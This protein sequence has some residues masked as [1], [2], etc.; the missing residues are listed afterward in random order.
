MIKNITFNLSVSVNHK[1]LLVLLHLNT[2]C[3]V[4]LSTDGFIIAHQNNNPLFE[5]MLCIIIYTKCPVNKHNSTGKEEEKRVKVK[6]WY[7][8]IVSIVNQNLI[9]SRIPD[10][11]KY[12]NSA[13][14]VI[15]STLLLQARSVGLDRSI[16]FIDMCDTIFSEQRVRWEVVHYCNQFVI[17]SWNGK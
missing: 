16:I 2:H 11:I 6:N 12:Y 17:S 13:M 5:D 15:N 4:H 10:E 9:K 1:L 14:S 7:S 3:P 8:D